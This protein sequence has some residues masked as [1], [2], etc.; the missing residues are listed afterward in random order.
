MKLKDV[1]LRILIDEGAFMMARKREITK[2]L[3]VEEC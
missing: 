2:A 1:N 3:E